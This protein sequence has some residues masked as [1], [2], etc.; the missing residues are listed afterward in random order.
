MSPKIEILVFFKKKNLC[1]EE[2]L[3]YMFTVWI[4]NTIFF[5]YLFYCQKTPFVCEFQ[6]IPLRKMIFF[7]MFHTYC[8]YEILETCT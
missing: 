3:E 1:V 5:L 7:S 8:G 2:A 6:H 4:F